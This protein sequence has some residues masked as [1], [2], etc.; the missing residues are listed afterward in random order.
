MGE[1][2]HHLFGVARVSDI[3]QIR[4]MIFKQR[5][6]GHKITHKVNQLVS[7]VNKNQRDIQLQNG[8][9]QRNTKNIDALFQF[10][11]TVNTTL[12]SIVYHLK[13]KQ[14]TYIL[15]QM[16][17][18]IIHLCYAYRTQT[19]KFIRQRN[20]LEGHHLSHELLPINYI[21]QIGQSLNKSSALVDDL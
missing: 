12:W 15:D 2:L 16:L 7:V 17:D 3:R 20:S 19:Q 18:Q 21:K 1:A 13:R 11:E 4:D 6:T 9:I 14:C 8:T 5:L 10:A